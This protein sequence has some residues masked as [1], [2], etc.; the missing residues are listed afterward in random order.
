[1]THLTA[2]CLNEI[3][4]YFEEDKAVLHSCLLVNRFWCEVSVRILWETPNVSVEV[5]NTLITCLPDESKEFLY[6]VGTILKPT[7]PCEKEVMSASTSKHPLFN[8]VSYCKVLS[9]SNIYSIVKLF[10]NNKQSVN[11]KENINL[12]TQ[13]IFKMF[14]GVSSIKKLSYTN[15]DVK[16][17]NNINFVN[18]PGTKYCL[19]NLSEFTCTSNVNSEVFNQLSK[20]CHNIQ[21]LN[22]KFNKYSDKVSDG[23][24]NL[25]SSQNNLKSLSLTYY[26]SNHWSDIIDSLSKHS[27]T[28]IKLIIKGKDNHWPL[29]FIKDF[30]NLQE[31]EIS[32]SYVSKEDDGY[33]DFE[34]FEDLQYFTF[35]HLKKLNINLPK[36]VEPIVVKFLENN[37]MNLVEFQSKCKSINR[38]VNDHCPKLKSLHTTFGEKFSGLLLRNILK[39]C[40]KLESIEP[41]RRGSNLSGKELLKIVDE[42]SPKNFHEL[43]LHNYYEELDAEDLKS[44]CISLEKRNPLKLLTLIIKNGSS[45]K[46]DE[47][48]AIINE[49]ERKGVIKILKM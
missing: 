40:K 3:F 33:S 41:F 46:N 18:F 15:D 26:E 8:Y 16:I 22:I 37:G 17:P 42:N 11:T 36:K 14:M 39:K 49:Y 45:R 9:I 1:M 29:S 12:L 5:L 31:L 24:K 44:F 27:N 4:R 2:D 47:K 7:I 28:L 19:R 13:E 10:F 38:A 25:I 21:S 32:L 30:K 48:E 20:I 6:K 35:P 34:H 23:L 43:N